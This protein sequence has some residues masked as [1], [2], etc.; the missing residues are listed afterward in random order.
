MKRIEESIEIKRPVDQ[1][2]AYV[3]DAKTW[4]RWD[5]TILEAEQASPGQ[6]GIGTTLR[7]ATGAMGRRMA[8]VAKVTEYE[9]NKKWGGPISFRSMLVEGHLIFDPKEGSTKFTRVYDVQLSGLFKLL[10]PIVVSSMR[11]ETKKS[12]SNLKSILEA[13]A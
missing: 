6:M 2:F 11:K 8:W 12:L 3:A 1:V 4:S 10:T 5:S 7:G 9:P 13:Q